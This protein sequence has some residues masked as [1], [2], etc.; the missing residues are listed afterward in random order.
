MD[1]W[2]RGSPVKA[3]SFA[4]MIAALVGMSRVNEIYYVGLFSLY[5]IL[6]S[7]LELRLAIPLTVFLSGIGVYAIASNIQMKLAEASGLMISFGITTIFTILLGMFISAI[8]RQSAERQGM[9]EALQAAR[10]QLARA[11]REAGVLEERQRLAREIHDTLAQ[12][13]TSIVMHLEAAEQALP[14]DAATGKTRQHLDRA[15]SAAR[16]SLAEAR[17]FVWDLRSEPLERESLGQAIRRVAERWAEESGLSAGVEISGG[18]RPLPSAYEVTLLRTAQEALAN[19]RKHA[20]ARHVTITL[21][22]MDDQVILDVQD[23]GQGF[24]P[25]SMAGNGAGEPVGDG[26][27]FGLIGMR[28]R[29]EQLGG[30]LQ[31]ESAPGEGATLV[32]ALPLDG[33][34]EGEGA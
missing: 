16:E 22:Y 29:A 31:I 23:D 5:G 20:E 3:I 11:E 9:I 4:V 26:S 13:F 2:G 24:D 33:S 27:G 6:F 19:V 14:Q 18:E 10:D 32:V 12:G 21:T 30:S 25:V 8:V 7:V 17:R 15:R 1:R 28:E 34:S